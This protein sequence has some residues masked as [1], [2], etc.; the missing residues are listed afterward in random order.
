MK[1]L[2]KNILVIFVTFLV[3]TSLFTIYLAP[4]QPAKPLD[5]TGMVNKIDQG[6]VKSMSVSENTITLTL[7]DGTFAEV[8][9]EPTESLGELLKNYNVNQDKLKAIPVEVKEGSGVDFW[10]TTLL[11]FLIPFLLVAGGIYFMMR[12]VP[13]G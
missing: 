13:G 8:K 2:P 7:T 6:E 4:A 5:I 3:L 12:P 1:N 9:K 10:L 11:P